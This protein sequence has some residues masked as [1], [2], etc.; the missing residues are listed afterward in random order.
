[1]S[2]NKPPPPPI[3]LTKLTDDE[4][5]WLLVAVPKEIESRRN[6][7][8]AEMLAYIREQI[9]VKAISMERLRAAIFGKTT[10][11]KR[12]G[13]E[14]DGRSQRQPMYKDPKTGRTWCGRGAIP[15]WFADFIAAGGSKDTLRI[16]DPDDDPPR[17]K[18]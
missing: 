10:A 12:A 7:R 3:D 13:S 8:E 18:A 14:G 4:L 6:K 5:Q 9:A 11:R 2:P 16:P 15:K 17:D 1:M